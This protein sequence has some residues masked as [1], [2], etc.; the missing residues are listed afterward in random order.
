M[1]S[2]LLEGTKDA[3][4]VDHI[5][6][7]LRRTYPD[8]I[9]FRDIEPGLLTPLSNVLTAYAH[10]NRL[11]GYC[12]G[13][14]YIVGLL[15]LIVKKESSCFWLLVRLIENLLP[16]FYSSGMKGIRIECGVLNFLLQQRHPDLFS[17]LQ[18]HNVDLE[19]FIS[20]WFVCLFMDVL[21]I[22]TVLRIWDCLFYEGSKILLR[23]AFTL[24]VINKEKL[25][26]TSDMAE[27]CN[28]FK[29]ITSD[30]RILHCH[31]F[32]QLCFEVP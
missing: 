22:E 17:H 4:F 29:E 1:F 8:N 15:L 30:K 11:V 2:E 14:N 13:L 19:L 18:K 16:D 5:S 21:P 32:M 23:V 3:T 7:D 27:L 24:I 12:Q 25:L 10:H 20:K 9:Y 31:S 28:S 6:R 26:Q